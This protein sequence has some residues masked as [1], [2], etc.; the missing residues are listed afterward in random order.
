M[1]RDLIS[2]VRIKLQ[3]KGR[4]IIVVDSCTFTCVFASTGS[5]GGHGGG[6]G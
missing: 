3:I 2:Y 4:R 1:L 6:C 5:S